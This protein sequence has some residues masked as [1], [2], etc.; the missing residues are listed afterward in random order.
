M[1]ATRPEPQSLIGRLIR[2]DPMTAEDYPALA[3]GLDRP[4][5]FAGG[6][7][8]GPAAYTGSRADFLRFLERYYVAE[9][10]DRLNVVARIAWGP[11]A[12]TV[13][14]ASSLA[15]LHEAKEYA[16]LG[17]TGFRPEV[18]GTAVNVEAKLLMLDHAFAHGYGRI[19]LQAD[20]LN[21]RSRAALIKL[22]AVFEGYVRREQQRADGSWR[23]TAQYSIIVDEWPA[24]R[25]RL[26]RRLDQWG[27]RP[28]V[29]GTAP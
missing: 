19:K 24:I 9:G 13:V 27:D 25:A 18:W 15:E 11:D 16:H 5:L 7:G 8:G 26:I 4:E 10:G 3:D 14:G 1:V 28:I 2:L 22:G 29:L 20:E 17:W 12:G 6:W 21:L 23:T